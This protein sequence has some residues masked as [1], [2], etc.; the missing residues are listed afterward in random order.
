MPGNNGGLQRGSSIFPD[1]PDVLG[2]AV[3]GRDSRR[4]LGVGIPGIQ[5]VDAGG[6]AVPHHIQRGG[7]CGGAALY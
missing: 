2:L 4:I 5:G 6:P 7:G 3:D 1:P